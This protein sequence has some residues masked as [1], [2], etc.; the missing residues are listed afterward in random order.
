MLGR[1]SADQTEYFPD[2]ATIGKKR[3][4]EE[5]KLQNPEPTAHKSFSMPHY[6]EKTGGLQPCQTLAPNMP[7]RCRQQVNK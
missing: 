6:T 5:T 3:K 1:P 7:R 4:K 2:G